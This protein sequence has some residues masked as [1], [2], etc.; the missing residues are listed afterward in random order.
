MTPFWNS[1]IFYSTDPCIVVIFLFWEW[2]RNWKGPV[3][4]VR[5]WSSWVWLSLKLVGLFVL[6][7][8]PWKWFDF[9]QPKSEKSELGPGDGLLMFGCLLSWLECF[10]WEAW[11]WKRLFLIHCSQKVRNR[12]LV[13][14]ATPGELFTQVL[15]HF[16]P[17][18]TKHS[19][20]STRF[21]NTNL[22]FSQS[23]ERK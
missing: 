10:F 16:I 14:L 5:G 2:V 17:H 20:V 3:G 9:F 13:R 15:P 6:E 4:N 18:L 1:Q 19:Q 23:L 22:L 12:N 11:L 21:L 8:W 7:V